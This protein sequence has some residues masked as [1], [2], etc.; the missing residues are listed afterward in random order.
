VT[1]VVD[2]LPKQSVGGSE[3]SPGL[4]ILVSLFSSAELD[5]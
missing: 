3:H 5:G 2:V 4:E 1:F